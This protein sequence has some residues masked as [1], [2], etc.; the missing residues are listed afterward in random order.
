MY[1]P[2]ESRAR[3]LP[4]SG[5][6]KYLESR[7]SFISSLRNSRVGPPVSTDPSPVPHESTNTISSCL[8]GLNARL[9]K[10]LK[11]HS[12]TLD[13][14]TFMQFAMGPDSTRSTADCRPWSSLLKSCLQNKV[15]QCYPSCHKNVFKL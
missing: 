5:P 9:L 6:T 1:L 2:R 12:S 11:A 4:F 8:C 14:T 13:L 7:S 3:L 10:V 15:Q